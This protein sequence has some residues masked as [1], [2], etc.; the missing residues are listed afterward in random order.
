MQIKLLFQAQNPNIDG[1]ELLGGDVTIFPQS[2]HKLSILKK[3]SAIDFV[4][5]NKNYNFRDWTTDTVKLNS[6]YQT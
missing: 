5:N 3:E 6:I 1:L 4:R 2:V